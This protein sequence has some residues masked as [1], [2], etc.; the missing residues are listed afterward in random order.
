MDQH[1]TFLHSI[2]SVFSMHLPWKLAKGLG[3]NYHV[4]VQQI[5]Q[6]RHVDQ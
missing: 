6:M 1:P 5:D 3:L 2:F 4:L